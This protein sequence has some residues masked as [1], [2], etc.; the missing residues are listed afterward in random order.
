MACKLLKIK[1]PL[2]FKIQKSSVT[3]FLMNTTHTHCAHRSEPPPAVVMKPHKKP[4]AIAAAW[5]VLMRV[6]LSN[7][8][9]QWIRKRCLC[10]N[11]FRY[12]NRLNRTFC[13]TVY[14]ID[15]GHQLG[16][17]QIGQC[18]AIAIGYVPTSPAARLG[19]DLERSS[20]SCRQAQLKL[21]L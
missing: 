1:D 19:G 20:D 15:F 17:S 10:S 14:I 16:Q 13:A 4:P 9:Q 2:H 21:Q 8:G 3:P 18:W 5:S 12:F 6:W 11:M 7:C